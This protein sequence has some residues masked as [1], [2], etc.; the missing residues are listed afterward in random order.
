[1]GTAQYLPPEQAMGQPATPAG[2][3][4]ALGV[5]AYEALAGRRPFSGKKPVDIAFA[6]VNKPVPPLPNSVAPSLRELVMQ[7]L[8]KE[9]QNRLA[10]ATEL[11]QRLEEVQL[12]LIHISEP[13]RREWLSRMPSSA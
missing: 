7:L 12:S 6:H 9:P 4:Y 11:M 10:S 3:L 5:I 2:D 8:E 1:M 13:T